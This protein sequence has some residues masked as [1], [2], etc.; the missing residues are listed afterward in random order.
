MNGL[1]LAR[2]YYEEY[3]KPML[4][5][6]FSELLPYLA[7]GFVG[8]GSEHYGFD[9]D[10][11]RDHDFEPGF[12][13]FLPGEDVV[14]R[15]KAFLL[16]R[17]YAKLPKEYGGAK[18]QIMS[19]VGGNRNGVIRTADFYGAAVGSPDGAL[20]LN[21]WLS[22]PDYALAEAVNGEIWLDNYG[23]FTRIRQSLAN[24]PEDIRL[25]RLAGN[26]LVMAQSGQYNFVRCLKHGEPEA[27]QL[28]CEEFVRAAM[29]T[30]F[31]LNGKYLPFYKWSFRALRQMPGAEE[32]AD[33]LSDI[34]LGD[35]RDSAVAQRKYSLI[36]EVAS[37]V[38]SEL[39]DRNLTKAICGDLEKHAYSVNDAICDG[40][41]RNMHILT[42]I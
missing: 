6:E 12:C 40:N 5:T 27:A 3:G 4:E 16:E 19:P 18:R 34:I 42:A 35:N 39:Q 24:M 9:D 20:S 25:K 11:S 28:A 29:K 21:A 13:I 10:I 33:K 7:V 2:G 26:I 8:S 17:A 14:D 36:E 31:L 37:V 1:E 41:V 15:R 38:I 23:E 30:V 32:L 22:I